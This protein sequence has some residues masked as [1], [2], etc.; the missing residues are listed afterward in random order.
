MDQRS[1]PIFLFIDLQVSLRRTVSWITTLALFSTRTGGKKTL[2]VFALGRQN[3]I[4]YLAGIKQAA[5]SHASPDDF[6]R[7][8]T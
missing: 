7:F 2:F 3:Q 6:L 1:S 8:S 5:E 4:C